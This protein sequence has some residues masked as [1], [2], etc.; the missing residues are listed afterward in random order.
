MSNK[1]KDI[2]FK[3]LIKAISR[4]IQKDKDLIENEAQTRQ[5]LIDLFFRCDG[6]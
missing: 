2:N 3:N 5:N 4:K 6:L 1:Y